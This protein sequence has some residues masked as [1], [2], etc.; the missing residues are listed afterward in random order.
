MFWMRPQLR[1]GVDADLPAMTGPL[2][3][4]MEKRFFLNVFLLLDV[5]SKMLPLARAVLTT[6]P[7]PASLFCYPVEF[8]P[9]HLP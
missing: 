3:E 2:T 8:P 4:R 5:N 6:T 7:T 1:R 9:P